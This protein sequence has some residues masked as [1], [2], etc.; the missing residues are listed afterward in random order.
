MFRTLLFNL[1]Q[2]YLMTQRNLGLSVPN[3]I[4]K[5]YS[6]SSLL[7][8]IF[9]LIYKYFLLQHPRGKNIHMSQYS[10]I[11]RLYNNFR[12]VVRFMYQLFSNNI[13]VLSYYSMN[14]VIKYF[15]KTL[16]LSFK[17]VR[18]EVFV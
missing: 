3:I 4:M 9:V 14:R 16:I 2:L 17:N 15:Y 1:N 7:H 5:N 10:C 13:L 11:Q 8:T 12:S 18:C 6:G